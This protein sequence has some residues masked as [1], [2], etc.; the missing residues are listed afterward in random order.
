MFKQPRSSRAK[1]FATAAATA[2]MLSACAPSD[3]DVVTLDFF[4]FKPEA[5]GSFDKIIS[6]FEAQNPGINVVQNH[7][8]NA[9]TAIRTLLVKNKTPDVL[10][11]NTNGNYGRLAEAGVFADLSDHPAVDT[12]LPAVKDIVQELGTRTPSEINAL[13]FS[14]NAS[15]ILYNKDI[16]A[17]YDVDPPRTWDELI[18]AAETFKANGVTPFYT[19]L[20]DAWTVGPAFV[21]LGGALQ[22]EGFFAD[23]LSK[24]GDASFS[25]DYPEAAEKLKTLFSYG[26]PDAPSKDYNAGNAAFGAGEAAMYLQ[27]SYAIPAIRAA[28]PDANIGSFPYPASNDPAETVVVSGVD[29]GIS[30]GRDTEHPEEARKFTEFLLSQEVVEAYAKEQSAFSPLKASPPSEDPALEGL[31]PY[32]TE[33][34]LIGFIDHQIPSSLPLAPLLQEFVLGGSTEDLLASLDN[35]WNKIA[36]RTISNEK[37]KP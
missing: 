28:N 9:D 34:R 12:V 29:V 33:G 19:T 13:P 1:L 17:K 23:L 18:E 26:Q 25:K 16:F 27:G 37:D 15:G 20:K 7:V 22:P 11:L 35:E 4:Q 8:P 3:T 32:F 31:A 2:L 5:V 36:A 24:E 21:N 14:S 10:T 6:E 30:I